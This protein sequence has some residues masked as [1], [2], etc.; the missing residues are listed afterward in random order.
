MVSQH[1]SLFSPQRMFP[2]PLARSQYSL[3]LSLIL[4]LTPKLAGSQ[5]HNGTGFGGRLVCTYPSEILS[6]EQHV[7]DMHASQTLDGADAECG[8]PMSTQF[9]SGAFGWM[10]IIFPRPTDGWK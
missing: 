4:T 8:R 1:A 10:E 3:G 5:T 6:F 9:S 7:M 2:L